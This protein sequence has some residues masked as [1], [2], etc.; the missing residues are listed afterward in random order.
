MINSW[1]AE[2]WTGDCSSSSSQGD[3]RWYFDTSGT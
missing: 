1:R 3:I 2:A